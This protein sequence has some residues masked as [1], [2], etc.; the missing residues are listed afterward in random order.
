MGLLDEARDAGCKVVQLDKG[1]ELDRSTRR[2]PLSLVVDPPEELGVMQEEIFGPILAVRPYDT[3]DEAI[4]YVNSRERPLGL[5]VMSRQ[6]EV[7]EQVLSEPV[8]RGRRER[9]RVQGACRR[10]ARGVGHSGT[11]RHP[12]WTASASSRSRAASSSAATAT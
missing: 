12:A 9:L 1:G 7:A 2:M 6:E 5:Y 3:L 11:G 10:S 8:R 4:D